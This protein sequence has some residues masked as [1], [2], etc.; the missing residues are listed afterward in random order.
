MHR[1]HF[2]HHSEVPEG[3]YRSAH[4]PLDHPRLHSRDDGSLLYDERLLRFID[5]TVDQLGHTPTLNS[6]YRSPVLN[7]RVGGAPRS[8]H[9][10]GLAVD[11]GFAGKDFDPLALVVAGIVSGA[12]GV[13]LYR[14]FVHFD[15]REGRTGF[16]IN[17]GAV[18]FWRERSIVSRDQLGL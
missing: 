12:K 8:R 10:Q 6:T 15:L 7:A 11:L 16:W 2:P 17:K 14:T 9:V 4:Y 3:W 1:K 13:G 18:A 5:R